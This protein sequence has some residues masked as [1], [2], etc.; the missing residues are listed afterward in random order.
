MRLL[1]LLLLAVPCAAG[2]PIEVQLDT[3]LSNGTHGTVDLRETPEAPLA[4]EIWQVID[5]F[6]AA[7]S[8]EEPPKSFLVSGHGAESVRG[9]HRVLVGKQEP[10]QTFIEDKECSLVFYARVSSLL[11]KVERVAIRDGVIKVEYSAVPQLTKG[12]AS[13]LTIIPLPTLPA[14][15]W[16]V[17]TIAKPL[18]DYMAPN[19]DQVATFNAAINRYFAHGCDFQVKASA[20]NEKAAPPPK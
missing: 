8:S 13:H 1:M 17:D 2:P 14:G 9:A 16:H 10:E 12:F 7:E 18:P 11:A 6:E 20:S 19:P 5:D 15:D 4:R 3:I